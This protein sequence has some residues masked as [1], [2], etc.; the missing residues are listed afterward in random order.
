MITD[1]D[2]A[3]DEAVVFIGDLSVYN[4]KKLS[5][6]EQKTRIE[7]WSKEKDKY[8]KTRVDS[9]GSGDHTS[10]M[11]NSQTHAELQDFLARAGAKGWVNQGT[12]N[13]LKS[14]VN[15]LGEVMEESEKTDI[16]NIDRQAIVRRFGNLNPDVSPGSLKTYLARFKK[17]IDLYIS[18]SE[19]PMNWQPPTS[20]GGKRGRKKGVEQTKNTASTPSIAQQKTEQIVQPANRGFNYPFPLRDNCTIMFT[21]LPRDLKTAEVARISAF[22]SSL[23][24]DFGQS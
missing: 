11:S 14:V 7:I 20:T 21:N 15:R 18:Y 6:T 8:L 1:R 5:N 9:C 2:F 19:N 17:A 12:A 24:E 4:T 13:A 16:G 3:P 22:L 10:G 23:A